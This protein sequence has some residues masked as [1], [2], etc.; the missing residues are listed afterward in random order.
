MTDTERDHDVIDT[1][2][3]V[4][5]RLVED[6]DVL[7]LSIQLTEG[8]ARLIDSTSVGFLLA[9]AGGV[10]HMLAG[11][12][13]QTKSLELFQLQRDEGPCLDC[14]HTGQPVDV[15]DLSSE[16]DRWPRF[17]AAAAE[18]GFL[19]VHAIPMRIG[20]QVLGA[21]GLF[22]TTTTPLADTD[23]RLARA[24]VHV[25][26]IALV[27]QGPAADRV[28]LLATLQLTVLSRAL[29]EMAK[30]VV[31]D[32]LGLSMDD[33]SML[34]RDYAHEHNEQL[35]DVARAV[36][37]VSDPHQQQLLARLGETARTWRQQSH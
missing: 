4:A 23:L 36:I 32:T 28:N 8:L 37:R 21:L 29:L 14:F 24:L 16:T 10:L 19:S 2:I 6:I 35:A 34:L 12:S 18:Q 11:T 13:P 7:D 1:F 25:A 22:G 31:A 3:G 33:A 20:G 9:D 26:C 17:V 15:P 5:D 27:Q 30:G